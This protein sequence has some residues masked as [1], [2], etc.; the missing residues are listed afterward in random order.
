MTSP[1]RA[2]EPR[3]RPLRAHSCTAGCRRNRIRNTI[4]RSEANCH[5]T[6]TQPVAGRPGTAR[7]AGCGRLLVVQQHAQG[8][9]G[10][11]TSHDGVADGHAVNT[12]GDAVHDA[13]PEAQAQAQGNADADRASAAAAELLGTTSS[14]AASSID[15][16]V[17]EQ[18]SGQL[19][20]AGRRR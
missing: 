9:G 1:S 3:G 17:S 2:R 8:P 16:R 6:Y 13:P 10:E 5:V 15:D 20:P 12:V 11:G 19:H 7:G 18:I 4:N 14:S